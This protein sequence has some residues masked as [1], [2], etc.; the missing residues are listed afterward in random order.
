MFSHNRVRG[1]AILVVAGLLLVTSACDKTA[2]PPH[3]TI[4]TEPATATSQMLP[5]TDGTA[6]ATRVNPETNTPMPVWSPPGHIVF[7]SSGS[8][9]IVKANCAQGPGGCEQET[10]RLINPQAGLVVDALGGLAA[11]PDGHKIAF[12]SR[13]D[14]DASPRAL[15]ENYVLDVGVCMS[16]ASGCSKEQLVRLAET[17]AGVAFDDFAPAW[18]PQG[19]KIIFSREDVDT[20]S[21]PM[22]YEVQPDG[23][24]EKPLFDGF[25]QD[26]A[27][28]DS[29]W[30]PD[31]TQIV[32]AM[33]V[34]NTLTS[35]AV[36]N[37][38]TGMVT[39]LARPHAGAD[40]RDY[41]YP[42]WS[43]QGDKI[44]FET[45]SLTVT[46]GY[47]IN[48]DGSQLT[49]LPIQNALHGFTWS[50]DGL[51]I[52]YVGFG[53]LRPDQMQGSVFLANLDGSQQR[54]LTDQQPVQNAIWIP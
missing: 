20:I 26:A 48:V 10:V 9:F 47:S 5:I 25:V 41:R 3:S 38:E 13:R 43:P 23:S 2:Q 16:S 52:A 44:I 46:V 28:L 39:E 49:R 6:A 4:L 40:D 7:V 30:S 54:Q 18:S 51:R 19:D 21:P 8:L 37:M 31:G 14:D 11:S 15:R 1:C 50:P 33:S 24:R 53:S 27:M 22:L 32:V 45:S 35:I 34:Q 42:R 17:Q 29:S 12:V 36:V